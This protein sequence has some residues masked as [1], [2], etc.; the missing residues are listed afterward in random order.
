MKSG[1][2]L[3]L[4]RTAEL[5]AALPAG[6]ELWRSRCCLRFPVLSLD[7]EGPYPPEKLYALAQF[8]LRPAL[9]GLP[10]WGG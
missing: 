8:T 1:P 2:W 7:L 10:G 6:A 4:A 5:Q 3:V 9:S